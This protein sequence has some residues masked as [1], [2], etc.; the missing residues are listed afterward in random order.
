MIIPSTLTSFA[1][2]LAYKSLTLALRFWP[3]ETREWGV[4]VLAELG[5][6]TE[7]S[8]SFNWAV[9]GIMLFFRA[10]CS[11]VLDW[12]RLPSGAGLTRASLP[13][14]GA[15]VLPRHSRLLSAV[16]LLGAA[17][18]FLLPM[19]REATTTLSASWRNF[20]ATAGDSRSLEK[21]AARAERGKDA[22]ELA[23]VA[24]S[25][26]D[27]VRGGEFAN[28]AVAMDPSLTW[29][30]ASRF[31]RPVDTPTNPDWLNRLQDYDPD[32]AFIYLLAAQTEGDAQL[33]RAIFRNATTCQKSAEALSGDVEWTKK[34]DQAFRAPRY[35][36]YFKRHR[37][38]TREGWRRT[39]GL[40]PSIVANSLRSAWIPDMFEIQTY[41]DWRILRASE[42]AAGN[43]RQA[44]TSLNEVVAFGRRMTGGSDNDLEQL[45]GLAVTRRGLGGLRRFYA[46]SGRNQ[47]ADETVAQL[48]DIEIKTKK[49]TES[50]SASFSKTLYPFRRKALLVQA[51]AGMVLLL[52]G[53]TALSLLGLEVSSA[54]GWQK[55]GVG[56]RLA[57]R[58][59]DYGPTTLLLAS[60]LFLLSFRPFAT[61]LAEYRSTN[62]SNLESGFF[63]QLMP[64]ANMYPVS[65]LHEPYVKWLLLTVSLSA[66]AVVLVL[67]GIVKGRAVA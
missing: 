43:A 5:E 32:N 21:L 57:C 29:I 25:H 19:G 37:E 66:V 50:L 61:A 18:L 64:L 11:R 47:D 9:G 58:L 40:S 27:P 36:S 1:E 22:C 67:R 28:R 55:R 51:S 30:Y 24:L 41:A 26:P 56:R 6:I 38:L 34:M 45:G 14:G 62:S 63:W 46:E 65:Y 16:I 10:V 23:F 44:E 3:E 7:P 39:P 2:R 60:M 54:F 31:R 59:A 17:I 8:E 42:I 20:E 12:L 35:D 52:A 53:V 13:G 49:I 4:A 33:H 15:P 48:H